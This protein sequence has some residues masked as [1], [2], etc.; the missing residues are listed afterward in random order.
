MTTELPL[1]FFKEVEIQI[2]SWCNR[3]CV[4]C[5]SGKFP[6]SKQAMTLAVMERI[7]DELSRIGF[8]GVFGLHLMC[9]PLLNKNLPEFLQLIRLKFPESVIRI[10]SN[11]DVLKDMDRLSALF[12]VGLNDIL[13]N[14][15]DNQAQFDLRNRDLLRLC[16]RRPDIWYWNKWLANPSVPAYARKLVKMRA[17]FEIDFPLRSWAGHVRHNQALA[18]DLPLKLSCP[19]PF[20]RLHVNYLGQVLLC[21]NDW[22]FEIVCGDL[23][24]SPVEEVWN[25]PLLNEY[26][27]HLVRQDRNMPL[28]RLC[29]SGF[30]LPTQPKPFP[31][32]GL[33]DMRRLAVGLWRKLRGAP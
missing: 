11:G 29:D 20:E 24:S 2:S 21:N 12:D 1:S 7:C 32:D 16:K 28:C 17:F 33:A 3:S 19:R 4:F 22:K 9:E 5:P 18:L 26:R 30:P 27:R 13:I 10:E 15:Y 14:C 25:S 31:A 8:M 6:I 23:M